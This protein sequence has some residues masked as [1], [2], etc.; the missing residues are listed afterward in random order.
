MEVKKPTPEALLAPTVLGELLDQMLLIEG[1][2]G[3]GPII[4]ILTTLDEWLFAWF[5]ED[6]DHFAKDALEEASG[7][8]FA[9]PVKPPPS[10]SSN[11]DSPPGKTPSQQREWKHDI[12]DD[13]STEIG[14]QPTT[15]AERRLNTS[16]LL[17]AYNDYET[18]LQFLYTSFKRMC[19]VQFN[20]RSMQQRCG[21]VLHKGKDKGITWHLNSDA[22]I[23]IINIENM[24]GDRFPRPDVQHLLALEDLGRGATGKAWL[25]CTLSD[26]PTIC[27]LKFWN[28]KSGREEY[29]LEAEK[30]NWHKVYPEFADKTRVEQW[31]GSYAL[32]MPHF[33][34]IPRARRGEFLESIRALLRE[35]FQN[36]GLVHPDVVWRN[37]G[38]YFNRATQADVPVIY[39]LTGLQKFNME[40]HAN[41]IDQA[42]NKLEESI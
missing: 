23:A 24:S 28:K 19:Q 38:F 4:G 31:S 18:V 20:Y 33:A 32:M 34:E 21:F 26:S 16:T 7:A 14:L 6:A 2:Y 9:T 29:Y 35:K 17:N 15:A 42:I 11:S 30:N 41:W 22:A 27:V 12:R 13:D 1:F 3:S 5:P 37:I 39:D 25:V 40:K 10:S 8:S 36:S